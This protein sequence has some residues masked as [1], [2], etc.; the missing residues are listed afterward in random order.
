[1]VT[2]LTCAW[3]SSWHA[4]TACDLL[5]PCT[6]IY[7]PARNAERPVITHAQVRDLAT[8]FEIGS[9]TINHVVL[10]SLS[11]RAAWNEIQ[12]SKQWVEDT[13]SRRARAFCYPRGKHSR[14]LAAMVKAAG[15]CGARTVMLNILDPPSDPY[16]WGVSTQA[17]SHS[18]AI[19]IRHALAERNLAGLKACASTFR[20]ARQWDEHLRIA[21]RHVERQGGIVH[22]FLHGWEIDEQQQWGMLDNALRELASCPYLACVTNGELFANWPA[23]RPGMPVGRGGAFAEP[24][25][26][27]RF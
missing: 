13:I 24:R 22:L 17:Y 23:L 26:F 16:R 27:K 4:S 20:F 15:F 9:H 11:A 2:P 5:H 7:I 21:M 1:M 6:K 8:Q 19:Q 12:G 3:P 14:G 18:P 10:T 25:T